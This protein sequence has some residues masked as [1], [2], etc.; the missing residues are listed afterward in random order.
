MFCF[1]STTKFL[2]RN[3]GNTFEAMVS[4]TNYPAW[5]NS[6]RE[7]EISWNHLNTDIMMLTERTVLDSKVSR[8]ILSAMNI[9]EFWTQRILILISQKWY[10]LTNQLHLQLMIFLWYRH[11][12]PPV[13]GHQSNLKTEWC[14]IWTVVKEMRQKNCVYTYINCSTL[15]SSLWH[16]VQYSLFSITFIYS[17]T[18]CLKYLNL[19]KNKEM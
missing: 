14:A 12:N 9:Q 11:M 15:C 3:K 10:I 6:P 16:I 1:W 2:V 8:N 17:W 5:K 7:T 13:T 19:Q 4:N 18:L